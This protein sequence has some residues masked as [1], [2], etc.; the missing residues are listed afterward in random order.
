M[1]RNDSVSNNIEQ[2][3]QNQIAF[4][5]LYGYIRYFYPSTETQGINW[6]KV[7]VMGSAFVN[8]ASN[9][10]ELTVLLKEFFT[11]FAPAVKVYLTSNPPVLDVKDLVPSDTSSAK[12]IFYQ[13]Y[14]MQLDVNSIVGEFNPKDT[15]FGKLEKYPKAGEFHTY[16]LNENISASFPLALFQ[17]DNKTYPP[18]DKDKFNTFIKN[19]EEFNDIYDITK[20]AIRFGYIAVAWNILQHFYPYFDVVNTNW[21][22]T[23]TKALTNSIKDSN[24]VMFT[25]TLKKILVDLHDGHAYVDGK[26]SED[27]YAPNFDWEWLENKIVIT[28]IYDS[29]LNISIGEVIEE[30]DGIPAITAIENT[31]KNITGATTGWMRI[32]VNSR[33]YNSSI[34]RVLFGKKN[35]QIKLKLRDFKNDTKE[36]FLNRTSMLIPGNEIATPFSFSEIKKG[37]VYVNLSVSNMENINQNI[38]KLESASGIIFDLRGYPKGNHEIIQHLIDTNV[39]SAIWCKPFTVFPDRE[40]IQF[41]LAIRWDL[42]PIK[43]RLKAK[44]VFLTNAKAISYAESIMGIIEAYKL[45]EI[46]GEPTAGTNGNVNSF[47]FPNGYSFR[48]TG[49]K[50][51]K[52][53]GSQHH[54]I[55]IQPTIPVSPSIKGFL[56]GKDEQLEK[57]IEVLSK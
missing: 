49:M 27:I 30:I 43:P 45:A 32:K 22:Q 9:N 17:I 33:F 47:T 52:H 44:I 13:H 46:I 40:N 41:D 38:E 54:G 29:T 20:P 16:R 53:N 36:L 55:G 25:A 28:K 24:E 50:V 51:L 34:C 11:P 42:P 48:F 3:V 18:A 5:K 56:S 4:T 7:A 31:E 1:T 6:E 2:Q 26:E 12:Q 57:A 21:N 14:E 37:I 23:L 35:T 19:I 8:N 39:A 10:S 15:I